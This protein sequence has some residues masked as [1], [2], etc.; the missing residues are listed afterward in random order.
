MEW[1][2]ERVTISSAVRFLSA[3]RRMSSVALSNGRGRSTS[4]TL[5]TKPSRRPA[6][7]W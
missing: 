6:G 7:T 2:P 3:K 4:E 5:E 1:A